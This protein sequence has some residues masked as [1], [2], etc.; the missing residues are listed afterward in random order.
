MKYH[1]FKRN[2]LTINA[3]EKFIND[4]KK[5]LNQISMS[6]HEGYPV[7]IYYAYKQMKLIK[8]VKQKALVGK[9]SLKR[10]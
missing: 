2:D 4:M 1:L 5:A 6:A 10:C 3:D 7:S 8:K 9:P